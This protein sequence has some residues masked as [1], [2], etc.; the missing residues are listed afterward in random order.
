[1][2]LPKN[3]VLQLSSS[4][5]HPRQRTTPKDNKKPPP[6]HTWQSRRRTRKITWENRGGILMGESIPKRQK[7][8]ENERQN[9]RKCDGT[10]DVG[11]PQRDQQSS[12]IAQMTT[13]VTHIEATHQITQ[14][15]IGIK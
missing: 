1:M 3:C 15:T 5:T 2:G 13:R 14:R 4:S 8:A 6:P 12:A 7:M 10:E 9:E 11:I